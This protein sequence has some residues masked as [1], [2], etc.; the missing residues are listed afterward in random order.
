LRSITLRNPRSRY[1]LESRRRRLRRG[2]VIFSEGP[3]K[4][5]QEAIGEKTGKSNLQAVKTHDV[6]IATPKF[7]HVMGM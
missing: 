6:A 2:D 5:G 4:A 7:Q 1:P 3:V